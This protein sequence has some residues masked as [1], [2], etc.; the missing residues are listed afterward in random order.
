MFCYKRFQLLFVV[1]DLINNH[2]VISESLII[3]RKNATSQSVGHHLDSRKLLRDLLKDLRKLH[4]YRLQIS[5]FQALAIDNVAYG[6]G[7]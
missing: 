3:N 6:I 7:S 2:L 4:C 5:I 1:C